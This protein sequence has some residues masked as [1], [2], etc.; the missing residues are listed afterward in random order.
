[1]APKPES[2]ADV[3]DPFEPVDPFASFDDEPSES[4]DPSISDDSDASGS[5]S[6]PRVELPP[7]D[8]QAMVTATEQPPR[9]PDRFRPGR[10]I[11]W[12]FGL[13]GIGAL[14][15]ALF[16][17][18]TEYEVGLIAIVLGV[19]AGVG[20][21]KGGRTPQSQV[22]GAV[23]AAVC[24]F[25]AQLLVVFG[26]L[27]SQLQHAGPIDDPDPVVVEADAADGVPSPTDA[28]A[29]DELGLARD[30]S[31][32]EVVGTLLWLVL[33]EIVKDTFSGMGVLFLGIA[34]FEGYRRPAPA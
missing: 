31:A 17:I 29:D 24:Y 30:A 8:V 3:Q 7:R 33:M 20:A 16:T 14:V 25:G 12:A 2:P 6:G 21:A 11:G 1:M 19:L 22:V 23:A 27:F 15:W 32:L 10:S 28:P 18:I 34:V 9:E 26:M 4:A 5:Q 13:G